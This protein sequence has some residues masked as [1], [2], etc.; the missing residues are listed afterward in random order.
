MQKR[1]ARSYRGEYSRSLFF[2]WRQLEL[3]F[4]SA[5]ASVGAL[6][7][8]YGGEKGWQIQWGRGKLL[9]NG[10]IHRQSSVSGV[11]KG[12]SK[13]PA[14]TEEEARGIFPK[15]QNVQ[16]YL[17]NK[18]KERKKMKKLISLFLALTMLQALCACGKKFDA[19]TALEVQVNEDVSIYMLVRY[20]NVKGVYAQI[21]RTSV[22]GDTYYVQGKVTVNDSYNDHYEAKFDGVYILEDEEFVK[23]SL[24]IETPRRK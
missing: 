14:K 19:D 22:D 7:Y 18:Q 2:V 20:E 9:R 10:V 4:F 23:Q 15:M 16:N 5:L 11:G 17:K 13:M 24:D 12:I 6:F 3:A 21:T 1:N 8:F